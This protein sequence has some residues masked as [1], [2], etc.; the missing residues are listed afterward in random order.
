MTGVK[1]TIAVKIGKRRQEKLALTKILDVC[2][3]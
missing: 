2:V 1:M 3:A